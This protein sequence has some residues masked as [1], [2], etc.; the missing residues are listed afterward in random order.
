LLGELAILTFIAIP[1]GWLLGLGLKWMIVQSLDNELFRVPFH[2]ER[3]K[4]FFAAGFC[5][6]AASVSALIVRRRIDE[7]DLI[8]V[9]KTR[10]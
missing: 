10:E 8:K 2:I 1:P 3:D 4:F 5:L 9:L 7:L 6:L